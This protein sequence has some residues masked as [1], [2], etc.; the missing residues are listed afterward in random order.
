[1]CLT[2]FTDEYLDYTSSAFVRMNETDENAFK[3]NHLSIYPLDT[4]VLVSWSIM[5]I[6]FLAGSSLVPT[7]LY[8]I[9][10]PSVRIKYMLTFLGVVP[11]GR[12]KP[13]FSAQSLQ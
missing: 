9:F 12:Q 8:Q 1:M 7:G 11:T 10:A 4:C 13:L 5:L 2:D 6:Y 3:Y